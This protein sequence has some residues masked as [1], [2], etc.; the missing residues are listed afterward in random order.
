MAEQQ[1]TSLDKL[2]ANIRDY[3]SKCNQTINNFKT[4]IIDIQNTLTTVMDN[5]NY[6]KIQQN[7]EDIIRLNQELTQKIQ[8]YDNLVKEHT[9]GQ[10]NSN[11]IQ[12][13]LVSLTNKNN[14]LNNSL[15]KATAE[16]KNQID[17]CNTELNKCKADRINFRTETENTLQALHIE[18]D[19]LN[20][21][22]NT[23]LAESTQKLNGAREG[24]TRNKERADTAERKVN[25]LNQQ[26]QQTN[27]RIQTLTDEKETLDNTNK[28]LIE[29][30]N[31][32]QTQISSILMEINTA[33]K[34]ISS[35]SFNN[36][37]SDLNAK[38]KQISNMITGT[39]PA[40]ATGPFGG[41]RTRRRY[42]KKFR[43][44]YTYHKTG[45]RNSA[46][47]RKSKKR[48]STRGYSKFSV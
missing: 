35:I 6:K 1:S 11:A 4:V 47:V 40:P 25:E 7:R 24:N 38:V 31:K 27:Q 16:Y 45:K 19:L 10:Q 42:T 3:V 26:I 32:E 36:I 44:G 23:Q 20:K 17:T 48:T 41:G 5:E 30:M 29:S 2:D 22:L 21:Q 28:Q 37:I 18:K 46:V 13:E 12:E 39:T 43:G 9:T 33:T 14:E 8:A 15:S 34:E